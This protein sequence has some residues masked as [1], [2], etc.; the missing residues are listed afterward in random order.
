RPPLTLKG[1]TAEIFSVSWSPDG[2]RLATG[3]QDGTAKVW[4]AASGRD[5][6]TLK[7]HA[8]YNLLTWRGPGEQISSVSWSPHRRRRAMAS[9]DGTAEV[10]EA[11]NTEAVQQWAPQARAVQDLL[12]RDAVRGPRAQGFLQTWLLLLP[13]PSSMRERTALA[14]WTGPTFPARRRCGH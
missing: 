8:D 7:E 9:Q 11:A 10:W 5:L 2:R 14:P 4:D 1:H 3:S 13:C 12:A 6:L